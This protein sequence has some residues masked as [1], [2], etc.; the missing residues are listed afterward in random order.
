MSGSK[1][2]DLGFKELSSGEDPIVEYVGILT[3]QFFFYPK[4]KN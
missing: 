4:V 1:R 3:R 2:K